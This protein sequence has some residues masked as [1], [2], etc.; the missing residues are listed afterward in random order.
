MTRSNALRGCD[1]L[2]HAV[3]PAR[4]ALPALGLALLLSSC[5]LIQRPEPVTT[6]R[7]PLA[8]ADLAWPA[9][10]APGR[11]DSTSALRSNR[12]LV[13]D[14]A[15]LM[16]HDGLRWVDT[17]AV[18]LSEQLRG[19]HARA[20]TREAVTASLDVWLGE[21]NLRVDADRTQEAAANAHA[22]L[23]CAGSD[24]TITIAPVSASATPANSDPQALA[25]A[26]AQAS[27]EMLAALLQ[28]SA[29]RAADCAAP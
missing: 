1:A 27:G 17:P 14:G 23:R 24:R 28:Q 13:V 10:L 18:M 7:L 26:F 8:H 15:V 2:S 3:R 12:V 19:L 11:V 21:L 4:R 25:D 6:L 16:Q 20:A 5:T 29:E 9:A 22:T